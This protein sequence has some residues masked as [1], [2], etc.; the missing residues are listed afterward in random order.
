MKDFF[1]KYKHSLVFITL[2]FCICIF[3]NF[4]EIFQFGP[5]STHQWRQS[6][7]AS[8]AM[9]YYQDGMDFFKPRTHYVMG[10]EGFVTGVGEAPI[11]YYLVG[12]FYKVFG[13]HDGIFRLLSLLT[14]L[15]G[16]FLISKLIFEETNDL[17]FSLFPV[18]FLM[19]SPVIAFYSFNFTPNIPAQG[20]SFIG[21]WFFYLFYQKGNVKFLYWCCFFCTLAGLIKV[22]ALIAFLSFFGLW[23]LELV[24]FLKLKKGEKIFKNNFKAALAFATVFAIILAWR[25]FAEQYNEIHQVNYFLAKIKPIWSIDEATRESIWTRFADKRLPTFFNPFTFWSLAV[26]GALLLL[27]PRKLK[28]V[29]Y[30]FY[31]FVI[32]GT[33]SFFILMFKQFELHDYYAIEMML[34]P[35][36]ILFGFVIFLNKYLPKISKKWWFKGILGTILIFNIFYTKTHLDSLYNINQKENSHFNTSFYKK[37]QLHQFLL[38]VGINKS[39]KVVSAPDLSPNNTLYYLNR[40]GWSEYFMGSPMNPLVIKYFLSC[41]AKYLIINDKKYLEKENLK[42]FFEYPLGDFENTIFVFDIRPFRLPEI[43]IE[44]AESN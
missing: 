8:I 13:A 20:L 37:R 35:L 42:P 19:A 28:F 41:G 22:S 9:N 6:D 39:D 12:I 24:G 23:L 40:K 30:F 27:I 11:F 43:E 3:Y 14:L 2:F 17:F 38:D 36:C 34:L 29:F 4:H 1:Q 33:F 26:L 15:A 44:G 7:S 31:L 21:I 5:R 16:F 25:S 18:V 32:L 10:G